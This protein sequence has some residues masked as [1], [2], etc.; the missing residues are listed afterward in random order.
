[1]LFPTLSG[2]N[3]GA[4]HCPVDPAPPHIPRRRRSQGGGAEPQQQSEENYFHP[5]RSSLIR[6]F[7]YPGCR[8]RFFTAKSAKSWEKGN[9]GLLWR[10]SIICEK[11]FKKLLFFREMIPKN[12]KPYPFKKE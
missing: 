11:Y 1:M 12:K 2:R 6:P 4:N 10:S 9:L 8:F 5:H 7:P 3:L